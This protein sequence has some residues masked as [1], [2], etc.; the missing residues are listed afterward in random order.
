M[1]K[2]GDLGVIG[3][4]VHAKHP[5]NL[6]FF[7]AAVSSG[8]DADSREFAAFAPAFEGKSGDTEDFGDFGDSQKVGKIVEI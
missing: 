4:G 2:I 6:F 7:V 8:I 3:A 5:K 1:E